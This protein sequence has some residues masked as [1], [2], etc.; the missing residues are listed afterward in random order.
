MRLETERLILRKPKEKDLDELYGLID[1]E[2]I[3]SI[4]WPYPLKKNQMKEFLLKWVKDWKKKSYWFIIIE[5]L[6]KKIIG[7]SGIYDIDKDDLTAESISWCHKNY[8]GRGY[9]TEAKIAIIDASYNKF[10]LRKLNSY[11]TTSN[12]SSKKLQKKFG[13]SYEGMQVKQCYNYTTKKYCDIELYGLFKSDWKKVLP[14][15]KKEL[16]QKISKQKVGLG[17]VLEDGDRVR[18]ISRS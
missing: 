8:R 6:S 9:I 12:K 7:V 13:M 15:L 16:R 5:K 3:A 2:I 18:I 10:E 14:K 1:R 11:I 17:Y 4:F